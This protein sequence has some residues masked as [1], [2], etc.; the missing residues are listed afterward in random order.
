MLTCMFLVQKYLPANAGLIYD[1]SDFSLKTKHIFKKSKHVFLKY[2]NVVSSPE[3][4]ACQC[5]SHR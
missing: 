5:S 1:N 4:S 2:K 3:I